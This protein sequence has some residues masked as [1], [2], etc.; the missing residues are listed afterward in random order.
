MLVK[1]SFLR[2]HQYG[3]LCRK[4]EPDSEG[5]KINAAPQWIYRIK[6]FNQIFIK[7]WSRFHQFIWFLWLDFWASLW[8]CQANSSHNPLSNLQNNCHQLQSTFHREREEP[9]EN[10]RRHC[11]SSLACHSFNFCFSSFVSYVSLVLMVLFASFCLSCVWYY[12][13]SQKK[14]AAGATVHRIN[15]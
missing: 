1:S 10:V 4:H 8:W 3:N 2:R 12:S 13:V 14:D 7:F 11:F 5:I 9:L 15:H 6:F